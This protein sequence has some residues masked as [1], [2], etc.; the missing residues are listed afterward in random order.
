[1]DHRPPQPNVSYVDQL[2]DE[3]NGALSISYVPGGL[4]AGDVIEA[5]VLNIVQPYRFVGG[6]TV[7]SDARTE[8]ARS[9][10]ERVARDGVALVQTL[11]GPHQGAGSEWRRLLDDATTSFIVLNE[12]TFTPDPERTT[13]IPHSHY[14][15]RFVG[16]PLSE[17][18]EGRVLCLS[19][20]RLVKVAAGPLKVFPLADTPGLSLRVIGGAHPSLTP[21]IDRVRANHPQTVSTMIGLVSDATMVSEITAAEVVILPDNVTLGDESVLLLALSLDRPVLVP[22]SD[23]TRRLSEEVGDGWIHHHPGALTAERLDEVMHELRTSPRGERPDLRNRNPADTL[24]HYVDAFS[25]AV[26]RVTSSV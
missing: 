19:P 7:S 5:D 3:G 14:R 4:P 15:D 17:S 13:L 21:L 18:V 25:T 10:A 16:Y 22:E 11:H 24:Q 9:V 2:L 6:S 23:A 26:D 8:A 12:S 20:A 1:M